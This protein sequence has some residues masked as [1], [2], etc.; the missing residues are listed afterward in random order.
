MPNYSFVTEIVL[1]IIG[2]LV[3]TTEQGSQPTYKQNTIVTALV[4]FERIRDQ[5]EHEQ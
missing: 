1:K 4:L 5:Q 2:D 3:E